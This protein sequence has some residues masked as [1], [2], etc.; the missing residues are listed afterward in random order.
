LWLAFWLYLDSLE[1]TSR[2]HR[3]SGKE[4]EQSATNIQ[5]VIVKLPCRMNIYNHHRAI[6]SFVHFTQARSV[7]TVKSRIPLKLFGKT[8]LTTW[9]RF[10]LY[11]YISLKF[12]YCCC[13]C[14]RAP[15]SRTKKMYFK[16]RALNSNSN[17]Q[18][19]TISKSL[20]VFCSTKWSLRVHF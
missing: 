2:S 17:T 14:L 10:L 8:K 20:K 1:M 12:C 19:T 4:M 13:C 11:K 9:L 6:H 16:V 7:F 3:S 15:I 18:Q 5:V